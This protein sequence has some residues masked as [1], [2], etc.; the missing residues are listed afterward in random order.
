VHAGQH[1][2]AAN[3]LTIRIDP[4]PAAPE[5]AAYLLIGGAF[6]VV[7]WAGCRKRPVVPLSYTRT[8]RS[9]ARNS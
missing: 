1:E 6:L 5:P 2:S 3:T 7:A 9:I 4:V 8:T